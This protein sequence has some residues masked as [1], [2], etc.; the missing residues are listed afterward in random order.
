MRLVEG[1]R[2][3]AEA[4]PNDGEAVVRV[5]HT[6]GL[7]GGASGG[8]LL[9][10]EVCE[11]LGVRTVLRLTLPVEAFGAESVG[12]AGAGWVR[13]FE[14]LVDRLGPAGVEVLG[15]EPALPE[16]MGGRPDYDVWQR[17][18]LWLVQEAIAAAPRRTLVAL[19][20]GER[21]DGPGG[22]EHLIEAGGRYGLEVMPPIMMGTLLGEIDV[23]GLV[24]R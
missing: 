11:E 2:P 7:A 21:G 18:N 8:D 3:A 10:H 4:H 20:D 5:G 14:A 22:T 6:T 13:R 12:A 17:T 23:S 24:V 19:W 16:W 9:F 15:E 1:D